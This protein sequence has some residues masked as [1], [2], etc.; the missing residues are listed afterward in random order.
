MNKFFQT[1]ITLIS[2]LTNAGSQ[3]LPLN[4]PPK[5]DSMP[6]WA[7]YLYEN[8]INIIKV[9]DAYHQYYINNTFEKNHYTRFY[10]RLVMNHQMQIQENGDMVSKN[11]RELEERSQLNK[12]RSPLM[13]E[14]HEMETFFLKIIPA[15]PWQVN[16]YRMDVR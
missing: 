1:L 8:P 2:V 14:L 12:S 11:Y 15:C 7:Q 3:I 5:A 6:E 9:E 10:K 13:N 16:V 4:L